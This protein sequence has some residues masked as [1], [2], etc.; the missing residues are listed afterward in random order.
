MSFL[1][2]RTR[3]LRVGSALTVRFLAGAPSGSPA[4][5][6]APSALPPK[7]QA[8]VFRV[9][10]IEASPGEFP[11]RS[12]TFNLP[13]YLSPAFLRTPVGVQ[14]RAAQGSAG[15][16]VVRLRRGARDVSAFLGGVE[17]LSGGPV[18]STVLADQTAGVQRSL[19]LQAVALR[20]MAGF[21]ALVAALI[22][23]QLLVLWP[24]SRPQ[25][26]DANS[27]SQAM[28]SMPVIGLWRQPRLC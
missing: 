4:R 18:G 15:V 22:L 12:A 11:P 13:V 10:G 24:L 25:P 16:L 19:H 7:T 5:S 3:H 9:V 17:R 8:V 27:G 1:V 28:T 14:A 23:F 21:A 6:P 2:A 26:A 20:L